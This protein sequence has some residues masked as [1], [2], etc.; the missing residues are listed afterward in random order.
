MGVKL[1]RKEE[2]RNY[3]DE[4]NVRRALIS[5]ISLC[6]IVPFIL[7][8]FYCFQ[9]YVLHHN[10]KFFLIT[11]ILA[12]LLQLISI[13]IF[14][15]IIKNKVVNKYK[16]SYLCY[17]G[18]TVATMVCF[19]YIDLEHNNSEALYIASCIYL[20]FVPIFSEK[21][22]NIFILGQTILV[23]SCMLLFQMNNRNLFDI[24]VI[25][26]GTVFISKYQYNLTMKIERT[27]K[28]LKMKTLYSEQD[29]LTGLANRRGLER[30][31][32]AVWPFCIRKKIPVGIIA[33]DID[34]FKK[35]NDKFGHLQGDQC[36]KNIAEAIKNAAQRSSDIVTRTGGEEFLVFVQDITPKDIVALAL[37]VRKSIESQ[38][39]TH[40]YCGISKYVTVSMGI[41]TTIPKPNYHFNDLYNEADK[42]LYMAKRNG[43]NC[44]VFNG[45]LY[46]R[47]KNGL[48]QIINID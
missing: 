21:L 15:I 24:I 42:A 36:L 40:A 22:K 10:M 7:I 33:L 13:L 26:F 18:I 46:G 8:I 45:N 9:V 14:Y 31:A 37:K 4:I 29:A 38:E 3:L 30:K 1:R 19:A 2:V 47:M 32:M 23:I 48:A 20:I 41:A 39:I 35:Y 12:E 43:R 11:G 25:Q 5:S 6:I 44:I 17:Y 27:S 34:Y 28:N 16:I